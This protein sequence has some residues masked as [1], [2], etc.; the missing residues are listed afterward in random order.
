MER[1]KKRR[2]E[3][4]I[5]TGETRKDGRDKTKERDKQT[6]NMRKAKKRG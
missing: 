1:C 6:L 3:R 2:D 4:K 5:V